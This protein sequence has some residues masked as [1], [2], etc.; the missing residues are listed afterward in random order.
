MAL[1]GEPFREEQLT[2]FDIDTIIPEIGGEWED[3]KRWVNSLTCLP[4]PLT[5]NENIADY[6]YDV[7]GCNGGEITV[8][9]IR[10]MLWCIYVFDQKQQNYGPENIAKLGE[11]GVMSRVELDKFSRLKTLSKNPENAMEGE[12]ALDAWHD[13]CVYGAIG[14]MVHVGDWP[15]C[16]ELG[17]N[18]TSLED[19][20]RT[21]IDACSDGSGEFTAEQALQ[22]IEEYLR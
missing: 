19:V 12:P 14:A 13:A 8:Q 20:C 6:L 11:A 17:L 7:V 3:N 22:H 18:R 15:T 21:W 2:L 4:D 5:S 1:P 9:F 16:E 10:H